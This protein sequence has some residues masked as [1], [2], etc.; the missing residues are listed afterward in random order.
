MAMLPA[1]RPG[2]GW[3]W[4]LAVQSVMMMMVVRRRGVGAGRVQVTG[5]SA[6]TRW[7]P[8]GQLEAGSR[9]RWQYGAC[10]GLHVAPARG[11]PLVLHPADDDDVLLARPIRCRRLMTPI[12]RSA[13]RSRATAAARTRSRSAVPAEGPATGDGTTAG[14]DVLPAPG[15]IA[16]P[17]AAI[18]NLNAEIETCPAAADVLLLFLLLPLRRVPN[19][20]TS[21]LIRILRPREAR[22]LLVQT[23]R[24]LI[25]RHCRALPQLVYWLEAA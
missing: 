17:V 18:S 12:G 16:P 5:D 22:D 6:L 11:I 13:A 9:R 4:I 7:S 14:D 8:P 19:A 25:R 23:L 20:G 2:A 15:L 24:I 10:T 1:G 3:R 21:R